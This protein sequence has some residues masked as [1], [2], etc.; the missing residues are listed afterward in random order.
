MNDQPMRSALL[1]RVS[2]ADQAEDEHKSLD[3]QIRQMRDRAQREGW[4]IVHEFV[5]PGESAYTGKLE[6]RRIMASV[7]VAAEAG[8]FDVLVMHESSRLARNALVDRQIRDRLDACGVE[9]VDLANPLGR[10]NAIG[11]FMVG[12]QAQANEYWSD[13]ISEH[14]KKA[15]DER[16]ARGLHCGAVPFGYTAGATTNDPLVVVE[17]EA[18]SIRKAFEDYNRGKGFTEIMHEWNALG[19]KPHS[20]SGH[21]TFNISGV[22]KVLANDFYAGFVRHHGQR[23]K[24]IHQAIISEETWVRAQTRVQRRPKAN[25]GGGGLLTGLATCAAC[26]GPIWTT[27]ASRGRHRY[28]REAAA[29]QNRACPDAGKLWPLDDVDGVVAEIMRS[30]SL[31]DDWLQLVEAEAHQQARPSGENR[32]ESL[33]AEKTR[34]TNA[35]LA[36][37]LDETE[38]RARLADVDRR[39]SSVREHKA[40]L[41]AVLD[42]LTGFTELWDNAPLEVRRQACRLVFEAAQADMTNRTVSL[43][44]WPEFA[45]FF[46]LR[47][48]F[49][50]CTLRRGSGPCATRPL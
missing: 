22:Q 20:K 1:A 17:R 24:G 19:L 44:P 16:F 4:L 18:A 35:Y 45:P 32:R 5:L 2:K 3:A 21:V 27:S 26:A 12:F 9:L 38:W 29:S 49:V 37:A 43:R 33:L 46:E 48:A 23:R 13:V 34:I 47:R 14:A 30:V 41:R 15:Y 25:I 10:K 31:G 42:R 28:Y 39:L 7:M 8:E 6:K 11:K 50:G 40:P 36:E